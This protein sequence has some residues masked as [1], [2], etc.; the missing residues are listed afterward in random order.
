M[1]KK[2]LYKPKNTLYKSVI[3]LT[4][5]VTYTPQNIVWFCEMLGAEEEQIKEAL[6]YLC[7]T[8]YL[9][10]LENGT[11]AV[12]FDFR[13]MLSGIYHTDG[14]NGH[15]HPDI[16]TRIQHSIYIPW[17][18]NM[19]AQHSDR[20][21]IAVE[22]ELSAKSVGVVQEILNSHGDY[23]T[24]R[25]HKVRGVWY[26]IPDDKEISR[27]FVVKNE[28]HWFKS[29]RLVY[30][31]I[32]KIDELRRE[33]KSNADL[34]QTE[35][36]ISWKKICVADINLDIHERELPTCDVITLFTGMEEYFSYKYGVFEDYDKVFDD[37]KKEFGRPKS[38]KDLTKIK[39]TVL[40][41]DSAIYIEKADDK[42]HIFVH[43][44]D[45]TDYI[46]LDS[47]I[48]KEMLRRCYSKTLIPHELRK[49]CGFSPDI[50][51]NAITISFF[52]DEKGEISDV[53]IFRSRIYLTKEEPELYNSALKLANA[54]GLSSNALFCAANDAA[55]IW[56]E[57]RLATT[58]YFS[59]ENAVG[60]EFLF[61]IAKEMGFD[62]SG[63]SPREK[64]WSALY[65]AKQQGKRDIAHRLLM[66]VFY[67]VA[68]VFCKD[69]MTVD[70]IR[71]FTSYTAY[72]TQV[73]FAEEIKT[74][75]VKERNDFFKA[76]RNKTAQYNNR[77]LNLE[78]YRAVAH[79]IKVSKTLK[80][81][82]KYPAVYISETL[83]GK[84]LAFCNGSFAVYEDSAERKQGEKLM[85]TYKDMSVDCIDMIYTL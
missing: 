64:A 37:Y 84:K 44:A 30:A 34:R 18:W 17:K 83:N 57:S 71:P 27:A 26:V 12:D 5:S 11:Y 9:Y 48:E 14:K 61:D 39:S 53:D 69:S 2:E 20:V 56:F 73:C 46:G 65:S 16:H 85:L 24:G 75:T 50:T 15:I 19:G 54:D 58:P 52:L 22:D 1:Q 49:K 28:K 63:N 79:N 74:K 13:L 6:D 35:K 62:V 36:T 47:D 51:Q 33:A 70:F 4:Q 21:E 10:I 7:Y 66:P 77:R 82:A 80:K 8:H 38:R 41:E 72:L 45:L 67:I 55:A 81:G 60:S 31:K 42:Y 23:F 43:V 32:N 3:M 29:N 76:I 78:C 25:L 59:I 68:D 40:A